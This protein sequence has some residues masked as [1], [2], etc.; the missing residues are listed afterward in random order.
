M[1]PQPRLAVSY[2]I[3]AEPLGDV[4]TPAILAELQRAKTPGPCLGFRLRVLAA[5]GLHPDHALRPCKSAWEVYLLAAFACGLFEGE[6]GADL[7]ARLTRIDDNN[8]R[9]ALSECMAAWYL[10]GPRGLRIEP[11]PKGGGEHRLEF[12]LKLDGGD[13]KVE[14]KAPYRPTPSGYWRGDDA[15]LLEGALREATGNLVDAT[16]IFL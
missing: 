5:N 9:S 6:H 15:D 14:V 4:F 12:A 1:A 16:A 10:A 3:P 8:F 13:I 2:P 11:R 7:R